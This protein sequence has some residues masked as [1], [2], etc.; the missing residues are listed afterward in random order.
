MPNSNDSSVIRSY[1]DLDA[2]QLA[3]DAVV[4]TYRIT[5]GFPA[6]ERFGLTAQIRRAAVSI[7]ANIAEGRS[8]L[9]SREFRHGVSIARGSVAEVETDLAIGVALDFVDAHDVGELNSQ[10]DRLSKMLFGLYRSLG[11]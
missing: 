1:R 3:M 5:R 11:T 9:G 7:P 2:W 10:L 8:R 4:A 6:D